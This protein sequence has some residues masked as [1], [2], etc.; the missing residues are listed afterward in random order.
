VRVGQPYRSP[1]AIRGLSLPPGERAEVTFYVRATRR[2]GVSHGAFDAR[3]DVPQKDSVPVS[4]RAQL[5]P[6]QGLATFQVESVPPGQFYVE[7][8]ESDL[9][10]VDERKLEEI[11]RYSWPPGSAW[12]VPDPQRSR[13]ALPSLKQLEHSLKT[14]RGRERAL[15]DA[16]SYIGVWSSF[17]RSGYPLPPGIHDLFVYA[18]VV[19]SADADADPS[20]EPCLQAIREQLPG[21]LRRARGTSAK[22]VVLSFASWLYARCPDGV[23]SHVRGQLNGVS[24]I[25]ESVLGCAGNCFSNDEDFRLF[26]GAYKRRM[27]VGALAGYSWIRAWRNL[28]RFRV[29]AMN[30]TV[31]SRDLMDRLFREYLEQFQAAPRSE[32]SKSTFLHGCYLA[33]QILKRRRFDPDFL[34]LESNDTKRFASELGR[35]KR[36][37]T[38]N[39]LANVECALEF[40]FNRA[41]IHVL[42]RLQSAEAE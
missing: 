26:Y 37:A 19:P 38:G 16:R 24:P 28:A 20:V 39:R 6:G 34:P 2:G 33:P 17:S 1:A 3:Q 31:L 18:G 5:K 27:A 42:Q 25:P 7:V 40:L 8:K 29:G 12:I 22:S 13:A 41:D 30:T 10:P 23:L 35:A 9:R 4:L 36:D 21:V 15:R 11:I 32:A 14:G